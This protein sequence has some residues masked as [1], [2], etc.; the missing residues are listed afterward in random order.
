MGKAALTVVELPPIK[1]VVLDRGF[2]YI[3]R[4]TQTEDI[5]YIDDAQCIRKWGTS[6][7]L[8]E[9][10]SGP[11]SSTELDTGGAIR[12]PMRA[13][14]FT[15]DVDQDKWAKTIGAHANTN[16]AEVLTAPPI[17]I[18][19]LDR[20]FVFIGRI[21]EYEDRMYIDDAQCIRKWG[22]SKGLGELAGGPLS[23]TE[24]DVGGAIRAPMRAVIFTMDVI[25]SKWVNTIK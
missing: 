22:T 9:L 18:V 6:K 23:G 17:R 13:V 16:F 19:V 2:V 14:I 1:I 21:T 7:G 12:A 10:S 25:Q 24:L 20:G 11:L 3:G 8:G 15:M 4:V 5:T